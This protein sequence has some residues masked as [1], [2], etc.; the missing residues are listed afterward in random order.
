MARSAER[1]SADAI[2]RLFELSLDMLGTASAE[3][4]FTRLNPA[5]EGTLGW[6]REELLAEP[7]SSFI[8]PDDL[9]ATMAQAARLGDPGGAAI[10]GFENRYRTRDG[11]YRSIEWAGVAEDGVYYF[12]ATDVTE[13]HEAELLSHHSEALLR[14]L[15]ANL[16]DTSVFLIDQDLRILIA[17]GAMMRQLTWL[18]E[19]MFRGRKVT[20]LRRGPRRRARAVAEALSGRA[21]REAGGVRVRQRGIDVRDPGAARP[22]GRR[23]GRVRARHRPRRHRA[24]PRR[25]ADRPA[26]AAAERH[27]GARALRPGEPRPQRAHGRGGDDGDG[28]ARRRSGRRAGARRGRRDA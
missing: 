11:G 14:T 7:F 16:P 20:E 19:S 15:T 25:A 24:H 28:H 12:A 23:H 9:E 27:R 6:T 10:V 21:G 2:H 26:L 1:P 22:R 4:Y 8:H 13:R 3:G 5:W 18:D 17:D